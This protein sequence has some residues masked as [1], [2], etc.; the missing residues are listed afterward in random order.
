MPVGQEPIVRCQEYCGRVFLFPWWA[1]QPR[2]DP[3]SL[4]PWSARSLMMNS[5]TMMVNW[6]C[7]VQLFMLGPIQARP[8]DALPAVA[9][10]I[11]MPRVGAM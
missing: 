9:S 4:P 1:M 10:R 2:L 11:V 8:W 6:I 3:E 7:I 5:F